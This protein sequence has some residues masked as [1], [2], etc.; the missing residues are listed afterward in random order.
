MLHRQRDKVDRDPVITS[1]DKNDPI[2][3]QLFYT[4][5]FILL[6]YFI[7]LAGY[8]QSTKVTGKLRHP[9]DIYSSFENNYIDQQTIVV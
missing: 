4:R 3:H 7:S 1:S 9:H 2:N 8:Q 5:V 6:S